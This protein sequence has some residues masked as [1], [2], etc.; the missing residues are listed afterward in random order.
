MSCFD[1][2]YEINFILES[3]ISYE[4]NVFPTPRFHIRNLNQFVSHVNEVF[5]MRKCSHF[6]CEM[7]ISYVKIFQTYMFS[8]C[9]M[10]CEIFVRANR[11]IDQLA[12]CS[13]VPLFVRL[14]LHQ[15]IRA[16][17]LNNQ[18]SLRTKFSW[19]P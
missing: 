4:K 5:H 19:C 16:S 17:N 11:P 10:T 13:F 2:V 9:E 18:T 8:T 6:I 12:I 15:S 3:S 1:A 14:T 7:K